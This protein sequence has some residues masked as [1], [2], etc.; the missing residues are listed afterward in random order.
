MEIKLAQVLFQIINFAIVFYVL[1]R[2][3]YKPVMKMLDQRSSKVKDGLEAA[4]K[5]LKIQE[6][7]E[8]TQKT[9]EVTARQDAQQVISEAKKEAKQLIKD[10]E[11][12]AKAEAKKIM[13]KEREAFEAEIAQQ[14]VDFKKQASEIISQA[15][16]A[17]LRGS[18]DLKLQKELIDNQV[19]ELSAKQLR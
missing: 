18:L 14:K 5:N 13:A 12:K 10:A 11:E 9:A 6:Q 3:V 1:N 16:E 7:L 8:E 19:K 17:V 15:T 2:F 4:E